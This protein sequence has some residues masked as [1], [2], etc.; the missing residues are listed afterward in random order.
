MK[1]PPRALRS[2]STG[3]GAAAPTP[4]PRTVAPE[5]APAVDGRL[6]NAGRLRDFPVTPVGAARQ[7]AA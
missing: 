3:V 6:C 7:E 4:V 1:R 5:E 2:Q